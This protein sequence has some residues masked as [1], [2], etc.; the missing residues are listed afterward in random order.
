MAEF[1]VKQKKGKDGVVL[2]VTG[3]LTIDH[4]ADLRAALL[5]SFANNAQVTLDLT[6]VEAIDLNG[7]QLLCAAHRTSLGQDKSLVV[8]GGEQPCVQQAARTAGYFRHT[9]CSQDEPKTCIWLGGN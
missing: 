8:L 2:K 6:L 4:V 9:G 5:D 3:R 7:L 1:G